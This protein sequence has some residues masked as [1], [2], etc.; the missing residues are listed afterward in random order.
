MGTDTETYVYII[1][2]TRK[3]LHTFLDIGVAAA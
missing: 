1:I 2:Y 3:K